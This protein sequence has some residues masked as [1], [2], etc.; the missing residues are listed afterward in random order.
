MKAALMK[1][2]R[3][4]GKALRAGAEFAAQDSTLVGC[5][6]IVAGVLLTAA[7]NRSAEAYSMALKAQCAATVT[8]AAV[9]E[10]A[11]ADCASAGHT[12]SVIELCRLTHGRSAQQ[13]ADLPQC[14]EDA[15]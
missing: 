14:L 12:P 8:A 2:F 1:L 6:V 4:P 7:A 11:G 10:L 13:V 5:A 9:I 15:P 3:L